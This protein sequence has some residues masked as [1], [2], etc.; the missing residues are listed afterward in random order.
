[1]VQAVNG[2][3]LVSL[4]TNL[5]AY[6][7]P[8][9]D[10][11]AQVGQ[12]QPTE[13]MLL[14]PPSTG[15]YGTQITLQ[16]LLTSSGTPLAGERVTF[17]IGSQR[18]QAVTGSDGIASADLP[19]LGTPGNDQV[20]VTFA[21]DESYA[22]S[23][24]SSAFTIEQQTT[25]LLL[26]GGQTPAGGGTLMAALQDA[27]GR[28]LGQKTVF[29]IVRG[30]DVQGNGLSFTTSMITDY[31]G[32][33]FLD[34]VPLPD[35]SYSVEAFFSGTIPLPEGTVTL[36]DERYL[37]SS[38]SG[39]LALN[40]EP[41]CY[42]AVPSKAVI[43]PPDKKFVRIDVSGISHPNGEA[44]DVTITSIFQDERV[45]DDHHSSPDGRGVG[46]NFAEVRAE[47]GD[48]RGGKGDGRVYHIGFTAT[49]AHGR[50]CRGEVLVQVPHNQHR[51]AVD[52]G[53]L[54]DSTV[55]DDDD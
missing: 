15:A 33:A 49:D 55:R 28:P 54:Y 36:D 50:S 4:S 32:Q 20:Q 10:P 24:T 17:G 25:S 13:L 7:I 51:P 23:W 5:G 26:V 43:W 37:P 41:I 11:A 16:A 30:N 53:A 1:M 48:G 18:H 42:T 38:A 44:L 45:G 8:G 35:G 14:S 46:G 47:R 52:G 21:G 29:F 12:G 19:L 9:I 3:G 34:E 6:F 22:S 40:N 27:E 2:V 39:T 31:A